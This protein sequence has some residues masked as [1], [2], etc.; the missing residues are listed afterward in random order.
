MHNSRRFWPHLFP[1]PPGAETH[2]VSLWPPAPQATARESHE[3]CAVAQPWE[4]PAPGAAVGSQCP[5]SVKSLVTLTAHSLG[6]SWLSAPTLS[7]I[8]LLLLLSSW[9]YPCSAQPPLLTL[10]PSLDCPA[11]TCGPPALP[12]S[13]R[14]HRNPSGILCRA[15]S[16]ASSPRSPGERAVTGPSSRT[17]SLRDANEWNTPHDKAM[18]PLDLL[19]T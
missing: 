3:D 18:G 9:D 1:V 4:D 16:G 5:E 12:G 6:H 2:V 15:P 7:L 10:K 17:L 14:G 13:S 8:F 11:N 19:P